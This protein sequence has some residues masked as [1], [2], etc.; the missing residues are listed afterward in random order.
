MSSRLVPEASRQKVAI[1]SS[2]RFPGG[3]AAAVMHE[4][5]SL[6]KVGC[7]AIYAP[8]S[9]MLRRLEPHQGLV[10]KCEELS[11]EIIEDFSSVV[12]DVVVL[13][14]PAMFKFEEQLNFK[15]IADLL[16][17]VNHENPL[18]AHRQWQ[19]PFPKVMRLIENATFA[20]EIVLAPVSPVSR[21]ILTSTE[22]PFAVSDADWFNII[23][24]RTA[25]ICK[26]KG[27]RRGRHSRPGP[28]KWPA[29]HELKACFPVRSQNYILGA[30]WI[31]KVCPDL[32]LHAELYDFGTLDVQYFLE[33][34]DF[35][36]YYHSNTWQ[37]SFGR[38]ISEAI[39]A[40]KMVFGPSYLESTFP[41]GGIYGD[42]EVVNEKI[43]FY[44]DSPDQYC[45]V[46]AQA[47]G[48]V[49]QY[50]RQTFEKIWFDK[51]TQ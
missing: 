31:R 4:L 50:D 29:E 32:A 46:V 34:I 48:A 21:Q 10:R 33:K 6:T 23:E 45:E 25:R 15:I 12:A 30:D 22:L 44:R 26:P 39:M 36:V 2:I 37:E 38:V 40:A 28:E 51:L 1:V 14:N 11:V 17:I 27:D 3:T 49:Q 16:V 7:R 18:T 20:N 35:F 47:Q 42:I 5:E 9:R 19:Y 41:A 8:A 13:H 43:A 24:P